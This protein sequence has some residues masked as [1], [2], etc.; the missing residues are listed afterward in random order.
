MN[1]YIGLCTDEF[2]FAECITLIILH[3]FHSGTTHPIE[4]GAAGKDMAT[5]AGER[6][7]IVLF[8]DVISP[9]AWFGFEVSHP[10]YLCTGIS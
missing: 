1:K 8:Y 6:K 2:L 3:G 10:V 4:E 7:K 9:F 5:L